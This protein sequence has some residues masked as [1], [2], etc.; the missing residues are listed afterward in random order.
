MSSSFSTSF[1]SRETR[2]LETLDPMRLE[3]VGLPDAQHTRVAYPSLCSKH[4][5]APMR[6]G[7]RCA[8][9]RQAHDLGR[10]NP[11]LAP[12]A[13]QIRLN[14]RQPTFGKSLSPASDLDATDPKLPPDRHVLKSFGCQQHDLRT[15]R[16]SHTDRIRS[17]HA[18][19]FLPLFVRQLD[20]TCRSHHVPPSHFAMRQRGNLSIPLI[21]KHCTSRLRRNPGFHQDCEQE[22]RMQFS[23]PWVSPV[24]RFDKHV[25][26]LPKGSGRTRTKNQDERE[27]RTHAE[28][29]GRA[30]VHLR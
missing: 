6:R 22:F 16:Q 13:R 21:T 9:R 26:S 23:I 27:H 10:I 14:R 1:G 8:L 5:R 11:G 28:W 4:A 12:T 2:N 30:P 29:K 24:P 25:L 15:P 17:G 7:F 19:Q 20:R 18:L 3:T